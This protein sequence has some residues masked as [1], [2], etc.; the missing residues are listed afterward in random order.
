MTNET[1]QAEIIAEE[2]QKLLAEPAPTRDALAADLAKHERLI[3]QAIQR[4]H[5]PTMLA[6]RLK[7]QGSRHRKLG[8][9]TP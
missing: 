9:E 7:T 6:S 2:M 3:R 8:F 1:S 5:I 4:G